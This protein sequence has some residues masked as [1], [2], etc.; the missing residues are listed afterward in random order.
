MQVSLRTYEREGYV[1]E[2]GE[3]VSIKVVYEPM[4]L[5]RGKQG[6][7]LYWNVNMS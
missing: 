1:V 5:C 4:S 2:E 7:I 6:F 3:W